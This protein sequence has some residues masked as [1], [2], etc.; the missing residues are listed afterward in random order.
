ME[1]ELSKLFWLQEF[2]QLLYGHQCC[3]HDVLVFLGRTF[4][5]GFDDLVAK[6]VLL[7][8]GAQVDKLQRSLDQLA[9]RVLDVDVL[10]DLS[11]DNPA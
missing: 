11:L 2:D 9:V 10:K 4:P 3:S 1:V 5:N 7:V 6:R 8:T